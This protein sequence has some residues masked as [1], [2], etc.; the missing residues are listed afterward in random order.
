MLH[1]IKGSYFPGDRGTGCNDGRL[2]GSVGICLVDGCGLGCTGLHDHGAGR[3][4]VGVRGAGGGRG[5]DGGEAEA[6]TEAE[7]KAEAAKV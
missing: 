2:G 5:G 4:T 6:D 7:A 3:C 1:L